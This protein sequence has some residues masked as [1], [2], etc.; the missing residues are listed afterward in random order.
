MKDITP[1]LNKKTMNKPK[2]DAIIDAS[3]SIK[4]I[5]K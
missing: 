1:I 5:L 2:I 4:I 3:G